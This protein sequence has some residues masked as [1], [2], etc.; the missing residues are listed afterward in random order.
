MLHAPRDLDR[1]IVLAH[2]VKG[3]SVD[4]DHY[5]AGLPVRSPKPIAIV[6]TDRER[7]SKGRT[8][9]VERTG[10]AASRTEN[11]GSRP[12]VCREC[13]VDARDLVALF[14]P[15]EGVGI[16]LRKIAGLFVLR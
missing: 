14:L 4:D 12:V 15:A 1:A 16:E 10:L 13:V 6:V 5:L 7:Q 8:E 11:A 2:L 3:G 9:E